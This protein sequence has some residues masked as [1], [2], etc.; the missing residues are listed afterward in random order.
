MKSDVSAWW[1]VIEA[2]DRV[3]ADKTLSLKEREEATQKLIRI[4]IYI[5]LNHL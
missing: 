3:W 1:I 2:H 5:H 4:S